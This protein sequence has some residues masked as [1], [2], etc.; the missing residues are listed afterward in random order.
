MA[1]PLIADAIGLAN[2]V[3]ST[4]SGNSTATAQVS[5]ADAIRSARS[6]SPRSTAEATNGTTTAASAP[7][8]VTS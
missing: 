4:A 3:T 8:A 2:S 7:P 5:S 6:R 1:L